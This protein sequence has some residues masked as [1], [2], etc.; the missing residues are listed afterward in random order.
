MTAPPDLKQRI[1]DEAKRHPA[2]T[3]S[4]LTVGSALAILAGT[5][6]CVALFLAVGGHRPSTRP[7]ALVAITAGGAL[8]IAAVALWIAVRR[9]RSML[10]RP[11]QWLVALACLTPLALLAWKIG[12]SALYPG[13]SGPWPGRI[14]LRCLGLSLSM[15]LGP[16]A[17][18]VWA[19]RRSDP[20]HPAATGL[21][22]GVAVGAGIWML[23]DLWCP[24]AYPPHLLLGHV[25]PLVLLALGGA[26]LGH[27]IISIR[28]GR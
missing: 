10:G 21:A 23:V 9:G 1:L 6:F 5:L 8:L 19:R 28:A 18:L 20:T 26:W 13:M 16:L 22:I 24:V 27:Q 2:P 3:R 15:G 25:L 4:A 7:P 17:A 14:G 11:L 12:W